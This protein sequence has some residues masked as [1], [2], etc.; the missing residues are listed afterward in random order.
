MAVLAVLLCFAVGGVACAA[1][2]DYFSKPE[3]YG[4][5]KMEPTGE[6]VPTLTPELRYRCE[7]EINYVLV[8]ADC[9][10][11]LTV[12]EELAGRRKPVL[13]VCVQ[14]NELQ[15]P[16]GVLQAGR[17]YYWQVESTYAPGSK[18]EAT[19]VSQRLYFSTGAE[20]K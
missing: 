4:P 5:G 10:N 6:V 8:F 18:S 9:D 16:A 20:S 2:S 14:A 12:A 13:M 3:V 11:R 7:G 1:W 15:I 19:T 17:G